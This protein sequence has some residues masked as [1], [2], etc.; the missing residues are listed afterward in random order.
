M[1]LPPNHTANLWYLRSNENRN[2]VQ[3]ARPRRGLPRTHLWLMTLT[4]TGS[5]SSPSARLAFHRASTSI[6]GR[7]G[8]GRGVNFNEARQRRGIAGGVQGGGSFDR[9]VDC[10]HLGLHLQSLVEALV[11]ARAR[12]THETKIEAKT[13]LSMQQKTLAGERLA[14]HVYIVLP[15]DNTIFL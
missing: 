3:N 2:G 15:P 7:D 12:V 1:M 6:W 8:G 5:L 11:P 13:N 4:A 10:A 9:D 14:A